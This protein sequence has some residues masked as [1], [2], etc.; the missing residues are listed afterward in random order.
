[1]VGR[2]AKTEPSQM[3]STGSKVGSTIGLTVMVE[4]TGFAHSPK[5]GVKV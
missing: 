1:M 2:G 4:V 3:S 5:S